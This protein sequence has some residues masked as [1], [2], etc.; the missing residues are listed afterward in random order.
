MEEI[1]ANR[2]LT[3]EGKRRELALATLSARRSADKARQER[4]AEREQQLA[5]SRRIAFGN[6]AGDMTAADAM[7]ARDA[8][9]RAAKITNHAAA[10]AALSQAILLDD[11]PYAKA[12][13]AHAHSRGWSDVTNT[14]GQEFGVQS[15]IDDLNNIP[16][17]PR[18][19]AADAIIWRVAP[20]DELRH[21]S[22]EALQQ[23][24]DSKVGE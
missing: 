7:S 18:T 13:A 5:T 16:S 9:D 15:F 24:A 3:Q 22:N 10:K 11:Q 17:G 20:P 19:D 21:Y 12:I 6:F 14:Y 2:S 23:L 4:A 8:A 1:R